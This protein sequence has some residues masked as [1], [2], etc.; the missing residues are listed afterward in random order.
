M[1]TVIDIIRHLMPRG[2]NPSS[3]K[4][5]QECPAWPPDLFGVAA[6]LLDKSGFYAEPPF[7]AGW[8]D[9][10]GYYVFTN[11]YLIKVKLIATEWASRTVPPAELE[12]LWGKLLKSGDID[13]ISDKNTD[14]KRIALSLMTIADETSNGVGFA[15]GDKD[16][17]PR[18]VLEQLLLLALKRKTRLLPYLPTSLCLMI[19]NTELCVQPKT[20]APSVGCT[21]RSFSHHLSLL[22]S[23]G[24]VA[25]SWLF[26][27][28][29]EG[30]ERP[31]NLLLVPYPF[32]VNAKEFSAS[33]SELD[34]GDGF[35]SYCG[36]W[37]DKNGK[38][39]TAKRI[40][41]ALS[42]LVKGA[43]RESNEIHGIVLPEMALAENQALGVA[44]ELARTNAN[45]ELLI[46]GIAVPWKGRRHPRNCAF[47]A[48]LHKGVLLD[49]WIQSK[50][51]RWRLDRSQ[52]V[53][54]HLGS[55]LDPA[56]KW[57]EQI[58]ISN[59]T[60]VFTVVRPGASLTV[61]VCEDLARFDPVG[62]IINAVGP[63]LV[64]AILM[65]GPQLERRWPGRYAT[66]LADDPGSSVL[67]LTSLGMIKRSSMPG[68]DNQRQ[69]A[70]WKQGGG[71][72]VELKLPAQHHALLLSLTTVAERQVTLDRRSDDFGAR[73]FL[74]SG[75]RGIRFPQ[76]ETPDWLELD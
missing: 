38:L 74:L 9:R 56:R 40:A 26:M 76:G 24:V 63:N 11:E 15:P 21:I 10:R 28:I 72:A 3:Y 31:L 45:L 64:V 54:Y 14:W 25:T 52:I 44:R 69:I 66:V 6:C 60:C 36:G 19:S 1:P 7:G 58:D 13:I 12:A 18:I 68:D 8:E 48:R 29:F 50:H 42:L 2:S 35:F 70:L 5:I 4:S 51:H 37:V 27:D 47:T 57:W 62:P 73:R 39:V 41:A 53:R 22:P 20:N 30:D 55:V 16:H 49:H 17:F 65:D 43:E 67:T 34:E 46:S 71:Q 75:A 23:V 61:L 59:R 33:P 32:V